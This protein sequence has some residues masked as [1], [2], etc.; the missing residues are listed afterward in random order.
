MLRRGDWGRR[1]SHRHM[2][3]ECVHVSW[4]VCACV[5]DATAVERG[6]QVQPGAASPATGFAD[7]PPL[8]ASS[9]ANR[10]SSRPRAAS[11]PRRRW[12]RC[13][14]SSK[15]S[16]PNWRSL[17]RESLRG[18]ARWWWWVAAHPPWL[19]NSAHRKRAKDIRKN[20]DFRREF[21]QMCAH[22]GV[23]PLAC[24]FCSPLLFITHC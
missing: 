23:D 14:S 3:W 2:G 11:W 16:R 24:R 9:H 12:S 21:Q 13:D 7:N 20:P 17:L 1:W 10:R 4:R 15:C 8:L 6:G 19:V 5:C 18:G 22:I